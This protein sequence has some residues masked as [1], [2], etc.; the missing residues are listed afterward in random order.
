MH[1]LLALSLLVAPSA[2]PQ[3]SLVVVL[4]V[5]QLRY[6]DL[7]RM[8]ELLGPGGV[9]GIQARGTLLDG[10]YN[11][12]NTETGPG[13]ATLSTGAYANEH[14]IVAN[15]V[16]TPKGRSYVVEDQQSLTWGTPEPRRGRS[17]RPLRVPTVGDQLKVATSGRAR[18]VAVSGKDRSAVL[19]AGFAADAAL[20]WDPDQAR[21]V[22]S[23]F[24]AEK[25]PAWVDRFNASH[26]LASLGGYRWEPLVSSE[27]L[28]RHAR[29]EPARGEQDW[30]GLGTGFPKVIQ[31]PRIPKASWGTVIRSTPRMDEMTLELAN[32]AVAQFDL[33][34]RADPDLLWVMLSGFDLIGHNFGPYSAERVDA[35]VRL[36]NALRAFVDGL[37]KRVGAGQLAIILT[38]DHGVTPIP[39]DTAQYRLPSGRAQMAAVG[40]AVDAYLDTAEGPRDWVTLFSPPHVWLERPAGQPVSCEH[41]EGA[42]RAAA[43]VEGVG[44]A[45]A[46]CRLA[47]MAS[48]TWL[49][50]H[51]VADPERSGDILVE[52]RPLWVWHD[53]QSDLSGTDHGS[54]SVTDQRVPLVLMVPPGYRI[55]SGYTEGPVD[56]RHV[57]PTLA[58]LLGVTPPHAARLA[59]LVVR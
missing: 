37:E 19:T 9:A 46:N 58:A 43:Q 2:A 49:P 16:W 52:V 26:G 18:V 28:A 14:G 31:E 24:Y 42:A 56:M 41:L 47:S 5:D 13:H 27:I 12:V 53:G 55:P 8:Q 39:E 59:S 29:P 33:G 23:S 44:R 57:A 17:P 35:L 48:P 7:Q 40:K 30:L 51:H 20:W 15:H 10:R 22:S 1:A 25:P 50:F 6:E 11:T 54:T 32:A 36:N 21:Y 3:P 34:R 4:V 45:V 38:S